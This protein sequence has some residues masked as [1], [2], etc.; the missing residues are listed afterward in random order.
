VS[1]PV[2]SGICAMVPVVVLGAPG[3]LSSHAAWFA[4]VFRAGGCYD[5][6]SP[7]SAGLAEAEAELARGGSQSATSRT[8]TRWSSC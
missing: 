7:I 4:S 5:A 2:I 8:R 6:C 1:W 3:D